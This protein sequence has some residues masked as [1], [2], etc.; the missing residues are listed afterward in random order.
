MSIIKSG[1]ITDVAEQSMNDAEPLGKSIEVWITELMY[2]KLNNFCFLKTR[3]VNPVTTGGE[4]RSL[5]SLYLFCF[6]LSILKTILVNPVT[7]RGEFRSLDSL[8]FFF[9]FFFCFC[10]FVNS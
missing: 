10:F 6:L 1:R 5:N 4:F 3:L 9:F 2:P 7:T 8:Y